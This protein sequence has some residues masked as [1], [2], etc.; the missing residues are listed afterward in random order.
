LSIEVLNPKSKKIDSITYF[1]NDK[2]VGK[3]QG[4]EKFNFP[5]KDQKLGYQNIKA[6]VYFE[7]DSSFATKRVEL[8]SDIEPKLLKYTIINTYPHDPKSFIQGLEFHNDTLY[9]STG[10]KGASYIRKYD[11]KTGTIYNQTDLDSQYF[12]EGIT[13]MDGKVF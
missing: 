10:Q 9:E 3:T 7:G 6:T 13:V 12:G 2:K 1:V 11:F 5:L 8:V 4:S